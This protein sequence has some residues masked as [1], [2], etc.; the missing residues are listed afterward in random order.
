[1]AKS[2]DDITDVERLFRMSQSPLLVTVIVAVFNG[3]RTLQHCIDSVAGQ[4]YRYTQLIVIDGGSTDDTVEIMHRNAGKI[5]FSL[6]EKDRGIYDAWNKGLAQAR[7][8]WICFLG[9]DDYLYDPEVLRRMTERLETVPAG[10]DIAYGRLALVDAQCNPQGWLGE[11][12]HLIK[13]KFGQMMCIPHPAVF[14]R[15]EFFE[16]YGKFEDSFKIAGDYEMLLRSLK[17]GDACSF[18][19]IVVV[20]MRTGGVSSRRENVIRALKE[21]RLAQRMHGQRIINRHLL[22]IMVK[23]YMGNAIWMLLG[24]K[25]GGKV[26][27]LWRRVRRLA[28]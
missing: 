18:M 22:S 21:V 16:K 24:E 28:A 9:S 26:V 11:E 25:V 23:E 5:D 19:D 4:T 1:M 8:D 7:G 3:G 13:A 15:R 6:S 27:A 10:I 2:S 12:W 20:G 14:H 17:E